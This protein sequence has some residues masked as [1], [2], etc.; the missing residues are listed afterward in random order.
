MEGAGTSR[1]TAAI[2]EK[3]MG[4]A[5]DPWGEHPKLGRTD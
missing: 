1:I 2:I 5:G 4:E 3:S